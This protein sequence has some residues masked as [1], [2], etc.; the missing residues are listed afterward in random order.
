MYCEPSS[1]NHLSAFYLTYFA[2]VREN[3]TAVVSESQRGPYAHV[4]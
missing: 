4:L 2:R 3:F 1:C